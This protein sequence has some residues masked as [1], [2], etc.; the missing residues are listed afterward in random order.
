MSSPAEKLIGTVVEGRCFRAECRPPKETGERC[1][2]RSLTVESVDAAR[3]ENSKI[4]KGPCE[5]CGQKI[6]TIVSLR[7]PEER[8]AIK[9]AA[10][11]KKE[12]AKNK[13]AKK[14]A[15]KN[16]SDGETVTLSGSA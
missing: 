2:K 14:R 16:G 15:K 7:T 1:S 10:A 4:V 6:T 5:K 13:P 9:K 12:A 8:E 11:D 3:N